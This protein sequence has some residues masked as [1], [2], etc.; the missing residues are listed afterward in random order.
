MPELEPQPEP[1]KLT[2]KQEQFCQHFLVDLNR[3]QAA[4]RAGYSERSAYE[5]GSQLMKKPHVLARINELMREREEATRIK[6]FKVLEELATVALSSIDHFAI[7]DKGFVALK[8]DAPKGALGAVARIR[9][10]ARVLETTTRDEAGESTIAQLVEY[11]TE[12][13]LIDKN[14]ALTNAMKHLGLLKDVVEHRDL[15]LEDIIRAAANE[16][17]GPAIETKDAR[18]RDAAE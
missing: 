3:T 14:P 9:R 17:T 12:I 1:T 5:L 18:D 2:R 4:I 7:D 6:G 8:P 10:K 16:S 15:T 13:A 11:D